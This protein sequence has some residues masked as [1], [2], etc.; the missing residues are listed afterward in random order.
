MGLFS[1]VSL[2]GSETERP[3]PSEGTQKP[4]VVITLQQQPPH[5]AF[6]VLGL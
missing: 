5:L 6:Q 2:W 4:A 1:W 3:L